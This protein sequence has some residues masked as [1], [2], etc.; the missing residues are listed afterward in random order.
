LIGQPAEILYRAACDI[1][2]AP[3]SHTRPARGDGPLLDLY[4]CCGRHGVSVAISFSP[5]ET[6]EGL[7]CAAI[8][9]VSEQ[10]PER[11]RADTA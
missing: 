9:D 8:R 5:I 1:H 11:R 4:G 10:A 3:R 2:A 6:A 7:V